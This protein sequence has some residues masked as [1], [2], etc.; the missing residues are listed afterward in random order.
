[1][2][3]NDTESEN[4]ESEYED[5]ESEDEEE[6]WEIREYQNWIQSGAPINENVVELDLRCHG[7]VE[8][9]DLLQGLTNSINNIYKLPN[10][11]KIYIYSRLTAIPACISQLENLQELYLS[12][13]LISTLPEEFRNFRQNIQIFVEQTPLFRNP[14]AQL[15]TWSS[16]IR[17]VPPL[18]GE[19]R[20]TAIKNI[21]KGKNEFNYDD[22]LNWISIGSPSNNK[23][24]TL[25]LDP[26]YWN[27]VKLTEITD[28][29]SKFPQLK[30]LNI[31]DMNVTELP[32]SILTLT[33]L[34]IL[35]LAGSILQSLPP[36]I[37]ELNKLKI[38]NLKNTNIETLPESLKNITTKINIIIDH[39][40]MASNQEYGLELRSWPSN[41]QINPL[42]SITGPPQNY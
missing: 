33:Q 17:F 42:P 1:M 3:L 30:R 26:T 11:K 20:N 38:V 4:E 41:F 25:M 27:Q 32:A 16:N 13:S 2:N 18:F 29:I 8:T 9:V 36:N 6:E 10:L 40:P 31:T 24:K 35:V 28:Q 23:V 14:P 39:T 19:P 34:E 21:L 5:E 15:Q 37:G 7:L 12:P 22:Y